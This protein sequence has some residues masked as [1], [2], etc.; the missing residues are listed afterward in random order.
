MA[1]KSPQLGAGGRGDNVLRLLRCG[2]RRR[3]KSTC[4]GAIAAQALEATSDVQHVPRPMSWARASN[5][6]F[7]SSLCR[8]DAG[9]VIRQGLADRLTPAVRRLSAGIGS[10]VGFAT[11]VG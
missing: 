7:N 4:N 1:W 11:I 2:A 5:A 3:S 9:A 10:N 8:P 6:A